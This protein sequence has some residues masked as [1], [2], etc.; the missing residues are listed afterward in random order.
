MKRILM[1]AVALLGTMSAASAAVLQ[2]TP[3][4]DLFA[5]PLDFA[6]SG[7]TFSVNQTTKIMRVSFTL[8]GQSLAS[9]IKWDFTLLG[10]NARHTCQH[11]LGSFRSYG[12]L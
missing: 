1:F 5:E 11:P 8:K 6:S 10:T 9:C 2:W 4:W 12:V 3:G 7:V